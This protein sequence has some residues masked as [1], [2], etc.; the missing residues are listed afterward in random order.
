[1]GRNLTHPKPP[2][3]ADRDE[4]R[5]EWETVVGDDEGDSQ[6]ANA[7][8]EGVTLKSLG[9]VPESDDGADDDVSNDGD[10]RDVK[11]KGKKPSF[12]RPGTPFDAFG[13][14]NSPDMPEPRSL[15]MDMEASAHPSVVYCGHTGFVRQPVHG[16]PSQSA[17]PSRARNGL[18]AF[19]INSKTSSDEST[20][21]FKYDGEA[22]STFL[23]PSSTR[24]T[25]T[26][27]RRPAGMFEDEGFT[28]RTKVEQG[29]NDTTF[30]NPTAVQ[31][32]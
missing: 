26:S 12:S 10:A 5:S 32:T 8:T 23:Q 19:P 14:S 28:L 6:M 18:G 11:G 30:Y 21:R 3:K 4:T 9:L 7:P 25:K 17:G 29:R 2:T 24:E 22:Y 15:R 20:D 13:F 31:S 16:G 1:M 27:K